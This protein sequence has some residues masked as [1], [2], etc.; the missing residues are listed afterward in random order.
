MIYIICRS[1]KLYRVI[2]ILERYVTRIDLALN[3]PF[4]QHMCSCCQLS[5]PKTL[6][7]V[8]GT[9]YLGYPY[10]CT[11]P[12]L[13]LFEHGISFKVYMKRMHLFSNN[14][15]EVPRLVLI[16]FGSVLFFSFF[17]HFCFW[18]CI[19]LIFFLFLFSFVWNFLSFA[20]SFTF[21]FHIANHLHF[22][23]KHK[24]IIRG[25]QRFLR[26]VIRGRYTWGISRGFGGRGRARIH[27]VWVKK[28][29]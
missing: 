24:R 9:R 25:Q 5:Q 15:V 23:L 2:W 16:W 27:R 18:Y 11:G 7:Y 12:D 20:F 10:M 4:V 6:L 26:S 14:N 28:L 8:W 29:G 13:F 1:F 21:S 17:S 22:K 3:C 19:F